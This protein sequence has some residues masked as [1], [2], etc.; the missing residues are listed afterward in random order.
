MQLL[1]QSFNLSQRTFNLLKKVIYEYPEIVSGCAQNLKCVC[2]CVC[3]HIGITILECREDWEPSQRIAKE[4]RDKYSLILMFI[5]LYSV[6]GF[7]TLQFLVQGQDQLFDQSLVLC[8]QLV[9]ILQKNKNSFR[10]FVLFTGVVLN[11]QLN[12]HTFLFVLAC[13]S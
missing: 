9:Y 2:V 10:S 6:Y 1:K 3:I 4:L 13:D 5:F 7:I 11:V 8:L 12:N